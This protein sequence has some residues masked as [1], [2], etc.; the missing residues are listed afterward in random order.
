MPKRSGSRPSSTPATASRSRSAAEL[1]AGGPALHELLELLGQRVDDDH[2]R[3]R[4]P[5][6]GARTRSRGASASSSGRLEGGDVPPCRRGGELRCQR[7]DPWPGPGQAATG[8]RR[9]RWRRPSRPRSRRRARRAA[10][11][12]RRRRAGASESAIRAWARR[13]ACSSTS[14]PMSAYIPTSSSGQ[15]PRTRAVPGLH[16]HAEQVLHQQDVEARALEVRVRRA[17]ARPRRSRRPRATAAP[18]ARRA[19][20]TGCEPDRRRRR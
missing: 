4:R 11:A 17:R 15:A 20:R 10:A 6:R 18:R 8:G 7:R 19:P 1:L 14:K 9:R 13:S 16:R 3:I 12:R 5:A 2:G